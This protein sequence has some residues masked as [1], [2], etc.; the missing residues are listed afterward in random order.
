MIFEPNELADSYKS[1]YP[2]ITDSIRIAC[3]VE[4]FG[5]ATIENAMKRSPFYKC[6]FEHERT[7]VSDT[8]FLFSKCRKS[9]DLDKLCGSNDDNGSVFCLQLSIQGKKLSKNHIL[10][11]LRYEKFN[12]LHHLLISTDWLER[13]FTLTDIL[14]LSILYFP[15]DMAITIIDELESMN[16]GICKSA[17]DDYGN[18]ALW[19]LLFRRSDY[20]FLRISNPF[21]HQRPPFTTT[22]NKLM[23]KLLNYNCDPKHKNVIKLSYADIDRE[24]PLLNEHLKEWHDLSV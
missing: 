13:V 6:Y 23:N 8:V 15:E 5:A 10:S 16:Q 18:N 14:F 7:S 19:Y 24:I 2:G 21:N 20:E 12:I 1:R 4:H 11:L 17:H 3:Y 9:R 22:S